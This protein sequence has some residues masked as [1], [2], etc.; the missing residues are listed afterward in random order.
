MPHC[1]QARNLYSSGGYCL[2]LYRKLDNICNINNVYRVYRLTQKWW[3]KLNLMTRVSNENNQCSLYDSAPFKS[4]RFF[5]TTEITTYITK[6]PGTLVTVWNNNNVIA[7]MKKKCPKTLIFKLN[8]YI[9]M[10]FFFL[11]ES[12]MTSTPINKP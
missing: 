10:H 12:T 7:P 4:Y 2:F 5:F 6:K 9:V 8:R 3:S 1:V 11:Y